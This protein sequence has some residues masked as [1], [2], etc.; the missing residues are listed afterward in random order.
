MQVAALS[1]HPQNCDLSLSEDQ[2]FLPWWSLQVCRGA[3]GGLAMIPSAGLDR[4]PV[5]F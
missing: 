2:L 5:S 1:A 3:G 4:T